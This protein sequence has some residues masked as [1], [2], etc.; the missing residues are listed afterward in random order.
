[1]MEVLLMFDAEVAMEGLADV[2]EDG[3]PRLKFKDGLLRLKFK[4]LNPVWFPSM[5]L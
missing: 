5:M 4:M 2:V 3:L 1:M